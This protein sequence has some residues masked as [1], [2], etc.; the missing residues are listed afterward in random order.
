MV[1]FYPKYYNKP[2]TIAGEVKQ[3]K[4]IPYYEGLELSTVLR[5]VVL[6][7]SIDGLKAVI[8]KADGQRLNVYLEDYY[9]KQSASKIL[10]GPGDAVSVEDLLPE[11]N[12]PVVTVRGAVKNP[13]TLAYRE[14]MKLLEA[15]RQPAGTTPGPILTGLCS[16]A[17]PRRKPSKSRWTGLSPSLRRRR[18]REP[19]S[20]VPPIV[21]FPRR[22]RWWPI[23]R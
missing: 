9:R 1:V 11:E 14:G 23:S 6:A 20:P 13:Q 15:R 22:R 4:V 12:L 19:P 3:N 5:S 8:T 16:Y 17:R 18:P 2:V 10:M 7:K 21:R